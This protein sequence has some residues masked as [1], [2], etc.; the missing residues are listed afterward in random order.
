MIRAAF[1]AV[2]S[3]AAVELVSALAPFLRVNRIAGLG[4]AVTIP[5]PKVDLLARFAASNDEPILF[6]Q[7]KFFLLHAP[8]GIVAAYRK[9]THLGCAVPFN[10]AEDQFHCNCHQSIYDK[11]TA[12]L[13][14]GPAPRGLDLFPIAEVEGRLVVSTNP[15]QV[16]VRSDNRWNDAHL[17]VREG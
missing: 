12:L 4:A 10:S 17:T 8:G 1:F 9:C 14:K 6:A 16:L 13:K 3:L 7:H 15:L 5:F 11:N 2:T